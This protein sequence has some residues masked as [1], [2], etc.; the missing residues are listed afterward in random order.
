MLF[1][2][3]EC[4]TLRA[5]GARFG[6]MCAI[7][8]LTYNAKVNFKQVLIVLGA[9]IAYTL[10]FASSGISWQGHFGGLTA[11]LLAGW[12]IAYAPR[13]RRT[14]IQLYGLSAVTIVVVAAIVARAVMLG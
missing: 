2:S 1:T 11:G 7:L 6:L 10:F 14:Q 3:S 13:E 4:S 9:N 12:I 8:V 5:S